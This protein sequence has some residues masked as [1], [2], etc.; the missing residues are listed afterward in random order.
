VRVKRRLL[1]PRS[2]TVPR[3]LPRLRLL[4]RFRARA[5]YRGRQCTKGPPS[6]PV[7]ALVP[8]AGLLPRSAAYQGTSL[9]SGCCF[10]SGRGFRGLPMAPGRT[11]LSP[12]E[13]RCRGGWWAGPASP[14][15]CGDP[16]FKRIIHR[17]SPSQAASRCRRPRPPRGRTRSALRTRASA[18]STKRPQERACGTR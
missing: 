18:F 7:V 4:L 2:P 11:N 1:L 3:D 16:L 10:G 6:T 8:G 12:R 13:R 9:G 15:P 14:T 17:R 5:C